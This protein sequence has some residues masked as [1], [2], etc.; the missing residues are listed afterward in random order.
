[1]AKTKKKTSWLYI[2]LGA[3]IGV[4]AIMG[5]SRLIAKDEGVDRSELGVNIQTAGV[6][7]EGYELM[8]AYDDADKILD[9]C[10]SAMEDSDFSEIEPGYTYMCDETYGG[11]DNGYIDLVIFYDYAEN[12]EDDA[13]CILALTETETGTE[14]KTII[15]VN[16]SEISGQ[17]ERYILSNPI[18]P[19]EGLLWQGVSSEKIAFGARDSSEN[20]GYSVTNAYMPKEIIKLVRLVA[21]AA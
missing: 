19:G 3:V 8:L 12:A 14:T 17:T 2:A 21:P 4:G 10:R 1:M 15:T 16:K 5:V 7:V 6:N 18:Y 11:I 13:L 20:L 9:I